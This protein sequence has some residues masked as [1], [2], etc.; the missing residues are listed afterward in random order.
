M[1]GESCGWNFL[2]HYLGHGAVG[3]PVGG[4]RLALAAA[5]QLAGVRGAA[6][7]GERVGGGALVRPRHGGAGRVSRAPH[8][9]CHVS[10]CHTP[11]L[12]RYQCLY[13]GLGHLQPGDGWPVWR[14]RALGTDW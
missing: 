12:S 11:Q 7:G 14:G 6:E 3:G 9:T 2:K 10:Q 4:A 13:Q 5:R 1:P 8:H